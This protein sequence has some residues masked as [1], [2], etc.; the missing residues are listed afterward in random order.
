MGDCSFVQ[1]LSMKRAAR[2][3]SASYPQWDGKWLLAK[4]QWLL[5]SREGNRRSGV[6]LAT[7]HRLSCISTYRFSGL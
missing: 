6:T 1:H 7:C 4:Q 5:C 3:N 2:A